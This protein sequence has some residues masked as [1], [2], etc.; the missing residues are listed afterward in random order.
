MILGI[1]RDRK[2]RV[3]IA[4]RDF[5]VTIRDFCIGVPAGVVGAV[6]AAVVGGVQRRGRP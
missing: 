3:V 1:G 5:R 2:G 4:G 6:G